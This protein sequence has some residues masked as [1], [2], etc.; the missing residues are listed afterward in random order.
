MY[1]QR[2]KLLSRNNCTHFGLTLFRARVFTTYE[3]KSLISLG[4]T[5]ILCRLDLHNLL[6]CPG[7]WIIR[8]HEHST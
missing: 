1:N 6:E 4:V 3:L 5:L 8:E 7:F 2:S